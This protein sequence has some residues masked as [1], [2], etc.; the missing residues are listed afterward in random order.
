[1][2]FITN[3]K[4]LHFPV[5]S[6]LNNKGV[7]RVMLAESASQRN[8]A[9]RLR[10]RVFHNEIRH[11]K[12]IIFD[13][14]RDLDHIDRFADH[15]IV[16]HKKN[17]FVKEKVIGTYRL[18]N[19]WQAERAGGFYSSS[20]FDLCSFLSAVNSKML[21]EV[22]RSCIH[23]KYRNSQVLRL[24]WSGLY[25]YIKSN[26]SSGLFG[27]ASFWQT[28]PLLVQDEINFLRK[29]HALDISVPAL[30]SVKID[31]PYKPTNGDPNVLM[32]KLPPL[33][34][35]YLRVGAKFGR[36]AIIDQE[37]KSIDVFVYFKTEHLTESYKKKFD[38]PTP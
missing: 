34:R 17:Q 6:P 1:M 5:K 9:L 22:S 30:Q 13:F 21:L 35:S 25:Q 20:E 14:R 12:K 26:N 38:R 36:E 4:K 28:D 10:H 19:Y 33:I 18:L 15:L 8:A 7:Y 32:Q 16:T 37:F 11:H 23:P 31:V 2:G 3:L 27:C 29:H 24:L